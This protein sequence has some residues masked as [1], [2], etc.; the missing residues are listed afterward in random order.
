MKKKARWW[1][2]GWT[3][4]VLMGGIL[5][6]FVKANYRIELVGNSSALNFSQQKGN[7]ILEDGRNSF[8][9]AHAS[10]ISV[11]EIDS[12]FA[13]S[14]YNVHFNAKTIRF[15]EFH[16]SNDAQIRIS[17]AQNA[18]V[19]AM[20]N[21]ELS[22]LFQLTDVKSISIRDNSTDALVRI[23][24]SLPFE[25][26]SVFARKSAID[27]QTSLFFNEGYILRIN[28]LQDPELDFSQSTPGEGYRNSLNNLRIT[29]ETEKRYESISS[30]GISFREI[31]QL[32]IQCQGGTLNFSI[33]G[34][35]AKLRINGVD[36]RK[37]LYDHYIQSSGFGYMV[38]LFAWL[39]PL[40]PSVLNFLLKQKL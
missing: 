23:S 16:V 28:N 12:I 6:F 22:T 30:Y 20:S 31:D 32:E 1:I 29:H 40:I 19:L 17:A 8:S 14:D 35:I 15:K 33:V 25:T 37:S 27:Y 38:L 11:R 26:A 9:I 10:Q 2:I 18:L 13:G 7:F 21:V 34:V 3:S 39:L 4:A 24:K 36:I 5:S